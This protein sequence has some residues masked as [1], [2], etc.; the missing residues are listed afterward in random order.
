MQI[1]RGW[2]SAQL[3]SCSA[4]KVALANDMMRWPRGQEALKIMTMMMMTTMMIM[5]MIMVITAGACK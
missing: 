5:G 2:L 1:G 3:A 4:T